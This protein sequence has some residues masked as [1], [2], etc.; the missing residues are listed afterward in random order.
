M[1]VF[2]DANVLLDAF[3]DRNAMHS[4]SLDLLAQGSKHFIDAYI[5]PHTLSNI[6]YILRNEKTDEERKQFISKILRITKIVPIDNQIAYNALNIPNISDYEDAL[7]YACAD[8]VH[9]DVICTNDGGFKNAEIK[10]LT[11]SELFQ[12]LESP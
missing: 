12:L 7:Q 8:A 2:F 9:A 11:A 1:R 4:Y 10:A 5:A 6:Y 3:L